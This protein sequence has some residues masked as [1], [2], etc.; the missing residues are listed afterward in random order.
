MSCISGIL[1]YKVVSVKKDAGS[2]NV[3]TISREPR[4]LTELMNDSESKVVI[5]LAKWSKVSVV[6]MWFV[7][8]I[9]FS[10]L[11][12]QIVSFLLG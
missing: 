11:V 4:P 6:Q 2:C 10:N 9:A 7:G 1:F 3:H 12:P 5:D 8:A